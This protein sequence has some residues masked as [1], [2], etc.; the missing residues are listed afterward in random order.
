[1]STALTHE[2]VAHERREKER[3]KGKRLSLVASAERRIH[4]IAKSGTAFVGGIVGGAMQGMSKSPHGPKIGPV[5]AELAIGGALIALGT[6][7][8]PSGEKGAHSPFA[9]I[10]E[11][12]KGVGLAWGV[13]FGHAI[14]ERKRVTGSFFP[15]HDAPKQVSAG[16][17]DPRAMA[18]Q[19][20]R[21]SGG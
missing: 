3:E 4:G 18:E 5:P 6:V 2:H 9:Y 1:M 11:L 20:I 12:G 13:D 14:G 16:V 10:T 21:Q 7:L 8:T 17:P 19:L 15:N